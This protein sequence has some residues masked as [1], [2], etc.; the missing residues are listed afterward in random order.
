M[1]ALDQ[2][3]RIFPR[4]L[5]R[6][7]SNYRRF[8]TETIFSSSRP[9]AEIAPK[10][11][12]LEGARVYWGDV[13]RPML[14]GNLVHT[15]TSVIRRERLER[16]R[17]FDEKLVRAGV[18]FDFHLRTCKEG[19]VAYA[20]VP[21][22]LYRIG[23]GDQMTHPSRRVKMAENFLRTITPL[24]ESERDR[25]GLDQAMIDEVMAE[26]EAF[27]GQALLENGERA[28]ARVHLLRSLR[29]APIQ[30]AVLRML[31]LTLL[32][33]RAHEPLRRVYRALRGG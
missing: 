22:I 26:G 1:N 11:P 18:D 23:L 33:P 13:F 31:A 5:R 6:M 8:Q 16:V 29:R 25:I 28:A 19:P 30:P 17:G 2:Q 27:L 15:S 21:T 7:Y 24:I 20:D 4:Y 3:G 9:L 10:I 14:M 32:P 12:G